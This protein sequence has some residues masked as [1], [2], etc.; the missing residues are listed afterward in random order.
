MGLILDIVP[1]HMAADATHNAWW[2]DVL[3][4]GQDSPHAACFDI[5][6]QPPDPALQ[7]KVLVPYSDVRT[8]KHSHAANSA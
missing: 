7:G 8:G 1:N 3:A 5:D 2:R 6:W 4:H